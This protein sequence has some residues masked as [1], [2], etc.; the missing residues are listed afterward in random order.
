MKKSAFIIILCINVVSVFAQFPDKLKNGLEFYLDK[1]DS[2]KSITLN[3]AAQIWVRSNQNNPGT[4]IYNTPQRN[5]LDVSIRRLR[6]VLSGALTDRVNFFVQ[7]GQNNLNYLSARKAGSFF[8]DA[9]ADYAI[10][11]KHFSIGAGLNGWDGPS[12]FSNYATATILALD[13]PTYQEVTSDTYDQYY[14]RLGVYTKGKIGK[15][16]YR[17]SVGKPFVIQTASGSGTETINPYQSTFSTLPPKLVYQSYFMYQFLD[18]ENNFA[19]TPIGSYLGK[20]KVFNIGG[21]FMY[22]KNGVFHYANATTQDTL[23]QNIML[24]ALDVFYD[25]PLNKNGTALSV[26]ANYSNYNYGYNFVQVTGADNPANGS[27][28]AATYIN[29]TNFVKANFGNAFPFLGTGNVGYV[30]AGY[31][32]KNNLLKEQGT[33]QP[34]F[35]LQYANYARLKDAMCMFD[36]GVNWLI[37]GNNS[38]VTFNYQNR[39][40]FSENANDNLVQTSRLG[41]FVIQYQVAF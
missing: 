31:K 40:Y 32:F 6:F 39:P 16:D 23:K 30:Q 33:L 14:R 13:P 20:K 41:E 21:G 17:V 28:N 2:S 25:A 11:K 37:Y 22:Q 5:T 27:A 34:Y 15:L 36:I 3:M 4:T 35:D 38:K 12:R 19:P 26:Y 9:T 18:Q 10:I 1:N 8:H 29:N 7:F 24:F